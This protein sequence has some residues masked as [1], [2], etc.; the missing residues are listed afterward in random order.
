MVRAGLLDSNQHEN[1]WCCASETS[2]E[3][4]ICKIHS[5]VE[6]PHLIWNDMVKITKSINSEPLDVIYTP[7]PHL[8][9]SYTT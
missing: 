3:V 1:K 7:S 6:I 8:L 4:Y 5:A 9:K 2:E